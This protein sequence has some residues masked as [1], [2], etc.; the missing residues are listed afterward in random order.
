MTSS[1]Q[2]AALI[3]PTLIAVTTSE[4][5][6]LRIWETNIAPV[7]YLNGLF[8]FVIGLYVVRSHNRWT[9]GWP[10]VVTVVGWGLILA[11]LFRMFAPETQQGGQNP[12]TL[13]LILV[14]FLVG[15]FLSFK[16]YW[17]TRFDRQPT[18]H[19]AHAP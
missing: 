15:L 17:P 5:L 18:L 16:A 12:P 10:V 8:F 2:L 9:R 19:P 1:K 4:T 11:G 14:L 7:T 3:G 6:N 13:A